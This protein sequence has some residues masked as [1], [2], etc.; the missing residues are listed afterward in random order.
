MAGSDLEYFERLFEGLPPKA[1]AVVA[2]R[3]AMR[4]LPVLAYRQSGDVGPFSYWNE[5]ERAQHAVAIFRCYGV[6]LFIN[7]LTKSDLARL[8]RDAAYGAS[9]A[10]AAGSPSDTGGF[11]GIL[12]FTAAVATFNAAEA[13][14]AAA[15]T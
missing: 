6:S 1:V 5:S 2:L 14:A 12:A 7:S 8:A 13:P 9:A 15:V 4:V 10:A 11:T 3:A